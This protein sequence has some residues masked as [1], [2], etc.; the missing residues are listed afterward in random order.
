MQI[1][2]VKNLLWILPFLSFILGYRLLDYLY[3][4][5][6]IV[7]PNL[8]GRQLTDAIKI[9]SEN[10]LN[11]R[12][13]SEQINSDL[14]ENTILMQKPI[15]QSV[16]PNQSIFVVIS[17]KPTF[18]MIPNFGGYNETELASSL[19]RLKLKNKSYYLPSILPKG[20]CICQTTTSQSD[21]DQR[22]LITYI[23]TGSTKWVVM[24]KL[25]NRPWS[26]VNNFLQTH[27]LKTSVKYLIDPKQITNFVIEQQP[28][29]GT[30]VNLEK[31]SQIDLC[32]STSSPEI[33]SAVLKIT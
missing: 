21:L 27:H 23:S 31:L 33:P 1:K 29:A 20:H 3:A 30:I 28:A 9:V 18:E 15:N 6:K 25:I 7:T 13:L 14:P 17:K 5:D 10:N 16:R 24:P 12:I 8:I 4:V 19:A 32:V 2:A 26:D 22:K 11:L